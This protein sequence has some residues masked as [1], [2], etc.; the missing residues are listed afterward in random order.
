MKTRR[1]LGFLLLT[2]AVAYAAELNVPARVTAGNGISIPTSGSGSAT[3]YL[4]GPTHSAKRTVKLGSEIRIAPQELRDAGRYVVVLQTNGGTESASFF[5]VPAAPDQLS[6]LVRPSRVPAAAP[7]AITGTAFVFDPFHNL[8]LQPAAVKF[9]LA[10]EGA[11]AQSRTAQTRNGVAWTRMDSGRKAGAA[12]FVASVGDSSVRRVVQQVASD[13]CNLRFKAMPSKAG[14]LVET[15]PVRDCAGN[16][17][18]DGTIVTFT[19]HD[20]AGGKSTVDARIKLGV[21]QAD[22]PNA[23]QA[24][25]SVASGVVVGNEVQWRGGGQ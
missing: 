12:Q 11:P 15:D 8:V 23:R 4:A 25:I 18:P 5:V 1:L 24:T 6:F 20:P 10:V 13:P 2:A 22:L 3:F 21:A 9:E 17:V 7:G 16:P 14:I 19:E